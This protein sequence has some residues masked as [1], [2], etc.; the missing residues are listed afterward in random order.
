MDINKLNYE[1]YFVDYHEESLSTEQVAELMAFLEQHADLKAEFEDYS[2]LESIA[3]DIE[4]KEKDALKKIVVPTLSINESNAEQYLIANIE[5]DLSSNEQKELNSFLSANPIYKSDQNLF[6]KSKLTGASIVFNN[7]RSLKKSV[8]IPL[9]IKRTSQIAAAA[10]IVLFA[11][12]IFSPD[13][14]SYTPRLVTAEAKTISDPAKG[15]QLEYD[16][17]EKPNIAAAHNIASPKKTLSIENLLAAGNDSE[18]IIQ[19]VNSPKEKIEALLANKSDDNDKIEAPKEITTLEEEVL[20]DVSSITVEHF[21]TGVADRD[22]VSI[23]QGMT[24]FLKK[25][26]L[27]KDVDIIKSHILNLE[28]AHTLIQSVNKVFGTSVNLEPTYNDEGDMIA[29]ALESNTFELQR[30]TKN[31]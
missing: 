26:V 27:K 16:L 11:V 18:L 24:A 5:G 20:A 23:K 19:A 3:H 6:K 30:N 4:F 8:V 7:K 2:E 17:F 31:K 12:V 21:K 28:L 15:V 29:Y 1:L 10:A 14:I 25:R 9:W 13:N 22:H